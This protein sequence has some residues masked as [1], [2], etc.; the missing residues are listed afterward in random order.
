[1][2]GDFSL[3]RSPDGCLARIFLACPFGFDYDKSTCFRILAL[4]WKP[5]PF[6]AFIALL[7]VPLAGVVD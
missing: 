5:L 3:V 2:C 1:M 6:S 7:E 4:G